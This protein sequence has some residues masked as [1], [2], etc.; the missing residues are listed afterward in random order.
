MKKILAFCIFSLLFLT[1]CATTAFENNYNPWHKEGYYPKE[2]Y[3]KDGEEPKIIRTNNIKEQFRDIASQWYWCLGSSFFNDD[4]IDEYEVNAALKKLSKKEKATIAL[5]TDEYTGSSGA[6]SYAITS[7]IAYTEPIN[8]YNYSAFLFIPI[9]YENREDY[10]PGIAVS[11]L[12]QHDREIYQQN[13]GALINI[14]YKNTTA[15]FANLTHGDIITN[16]NGKR[17]NSPEDYFDVLEKSKIGDI[18]NITFVRNG[19][20]RHVE[21][22]F[23]L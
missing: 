11:E 23:K 14:V 5:W 12:S 18:W 19:Q 3:L 16:I 6:M 21:I 4:E 15:F 17:I 10:T 9:P 1:G 2:A 20:E 8:Q 7:T 22:P 13:T